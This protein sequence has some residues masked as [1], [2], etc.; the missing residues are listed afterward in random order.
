MAAPASVAAH[1]VPRQSQVGGFILPGGDGDGAAQLAIDLHGDGDLVL[2]QPGRVS[3]R[4]GAGS[5]PCRRPA[6]GPQRF[7]RRGAA[8]SAHTR[9]AMVTAAS[10]RGKTQ[11]LGA[12]I[13]AGQSA[14][15]FI[16]PGD[17]KVESESLQRLGHRGDGAVG[18]LAEFFW[19]RR[20]D[21]RVPRR[22]GAA[23]M[24]LAILASRCM[25][26]KAPCTPG[27]GP[28][29]RRAPADCRTA[30]TSARCR[31]RNAR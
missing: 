17:S 23:A 4:P 21:W 26:R 27:L 1:R 18:E 6:A 13:G 28:I 31:R 7:P 11:V 29:P 30:R 15:Q 14:G 2:D 10:K 9:W 24:V 19:P 5:P 20:R 12:R 16:N 25:K 22:G 8:S 3:F